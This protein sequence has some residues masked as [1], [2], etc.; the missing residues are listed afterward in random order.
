MRKLIAILT[1]ITTLIGYHISL[2]AS[3][4]D[5]ANTIIINALKSAK[6]QTIQDLYNFVNKQFKQTDLFYWYTTGI[7]FVIQIVKN[8]YKDPTFKTESVI[9][10]NDGTVWYMN[11]HTITSIN[12]IIIEKFNSYCPE[13]K[14]LIT[15]YNYT[16]Y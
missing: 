5:N 3:P 9:I 12:G 4:L 6:I 11:Q 13:I 15:G 2:A 10:G 14:T 16:F 1:V 7:S 8:H